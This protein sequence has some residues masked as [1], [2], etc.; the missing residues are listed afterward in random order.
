MID[1]VG[2]NGPSTG[3]GPLNKMSDLNGYPGR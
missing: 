1:E 3:S 2:Y